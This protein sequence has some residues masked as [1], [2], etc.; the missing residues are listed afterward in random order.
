[1]SAAM[2]ATFTS[3]ALRPRREIRSLYVRDPDGYVLGF[4]QP[5]TEDGNA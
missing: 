5:T 2:V 4:I 1:M 3:I